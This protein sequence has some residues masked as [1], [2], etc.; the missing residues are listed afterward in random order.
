M[1]DLSFVQECVIDSE[2]EVR[3]TIDMVYIK[4]K[5]I[6]EYVSNS[7]D[8][9][10]HYYLESSNVP[11]GSNK[12]FDL[13]SF[14]NDHIIRAIK[15]FNKAYADLSFSSKRSE[16]NQ[17][18]REIEEGELTFKS[19][20][21]ELNKPPKE[22]IDELRKN[23]LSNNGHFIKGFKELE[24]QF[25]CKFEV[26]L[27]Q[28]T[29]TG[30][31]L[32]K[33]PSDAKV[34]KITISRKK[35]FQLGGLPIIINVNPS[36]I[37]AIVPSN[38]KLF[39]QTL[40][41]IILHEIYHNIVHCVDIRNK[42]LHNDIKK[43]FGNLTGEENKKTVDSKTNAF[44]SRFKS[45]F[46]IKN[47]EFNEERTRN[48]F[49]VLSKIKDNPNAMKRFEADIKSNVDKTNSEKELDDY[50]NTLQKIKT[51]TGFRKVPRMIALAGAILL[52][53]LGFAFG[54]TLMAASGIVYVAIVAL[55]MLIKK[56]LSFFTVSVGL[57]EEYFCDLFAA[58]YNLPIHL[59][60]YKRQIQLNKLHSKKVKKIHDLN[61]DI[62]ANVKDEHP[63]TFDREVVSYQA[64]KR[65]LDSGKHLKP[66]IKK[67]L[68]YIVKQHEG[69]EDIEQKHTR[70]QLKQMDPEAAKDLQKTV[71]DF[72]RQTGV[73]VTE[74]FVD[75]VEDVI[76]DYYLEIEDGD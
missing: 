57:Q 38:R 55:S 56:V 45:A 6:E 58:M 52:A 21:H 51:A 8:E 72:V 67:Y 59:T 11:V 63:M 47:S 62:S 13:F 75:E 65:I 16:Y 61:S 19:E 26:Y 15:H 43:T 60:S 4:H 24:K 34:N 64:A 10:L 48:R 53:G 46:T 35:G 74:S 66:E 7:N 31:A 27:S 37:L 54:S 30:T 12:T 76:L 29:G 17:K 73:A 71:D 68:K 25:D 22:F 5:M 49:Y 23:F 50:I 9:S 69:I 1:V 20:Y 44:I 18:K 40:T 33:F 42:N 36:Q 2:E 28:A 3:N 70:Q 41:A 14:N 32:T 39:G